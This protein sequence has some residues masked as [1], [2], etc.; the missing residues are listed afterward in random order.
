MKTASATLEDNTLDTEC[1][2]C[3]NI[4]FYKLNQV[5]TQVLCPYCN[6]KIDLE[7]SGIL[8]ALKDVDKAFDNLF[9]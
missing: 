4:I 1:P 6:A 5:G 2:N 9:K 3:G 8:S 7:D